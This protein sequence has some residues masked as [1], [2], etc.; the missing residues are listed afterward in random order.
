MH[1]VHL[2]ARLNDGGPARVV[3]DL[4]SAAQAAGHQVT[5]LS[6]QVGPDEVDMTAAL[7][8]AGISVEILPRLSSTVAPLADLTALLRCH[9]RLRQLA[10]DVLHTHTAKAGAIGRLVARALGIPCLHSYHGHVLHGYFRPGINTAV[11]LIERALASTGH[12]HSLTPSLCTELSQRHRIGAA[13]RW[14]CLPVPVAA[15]E[16][17]AAGWHAQ[18]V[19][20]RPVVTFLGRLA[21]VKDIDLWLATLTALNQLRPVQG[22]ICGDGPL[23]QHAEQRAAQCGLPI[24]VAGHVPAAEAFG[25][26]DLLLMSSRN[27]GMPLV[28]VEAASAGIPVVAPAVGGLVDCARWGLVKAVDRN[29]GALAQRCA[30][31]LGTTPEPCLL[32][33]RAAQFA[34]ERVVP[35]YLELYTRLCKTSAP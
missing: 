31:V 1:I 22:L 25:A 18:L 15:V 10:P 19:P 8:D 4:A 28:A 12:C 13:H 16:P 24:H 33:Q 21:P 2:I 20:D 34:P 5:V 17:S 26:T 9:Q 3:R 11:R 14:H 30:M 35:R 32:R 23:R 6:G 7:Q 29:P 27:E